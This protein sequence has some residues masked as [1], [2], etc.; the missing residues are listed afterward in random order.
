MILTLRLHSRGKKIFRKFSDSFDDDNDP[1]EGEESADMEDLGE[2]HPRRVTRSSIKPRLLFQTKDKGKEAAAIA[3]AEEEEAV[4]D[5]E[6][7]VFADA[8]EV[9]VPETPMIVADER[10]KTPDAPRFGPASPP[11]TTRATRS[12]DKLNT[13]VSKPSKVP[14]PFDGWRR[15][16]SRA[17]PTGQKRGGDFLAKSPAGTKRQRA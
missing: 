6:D 15:S 13:P 2:A 4:T 1:L 7:H 14:S 3:Q 11:S 17:A 12:T 16:K 10:A 8:E 5:I 9:E